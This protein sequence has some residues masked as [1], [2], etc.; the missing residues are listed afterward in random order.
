[1]DNRKKLA[2]SIIN[3]LKTEASSDKL[4]ED[5][6]EGL[7]VAIQCLETAYGLEDVNTSMSIDLFQIFND[8]LSKS[9]EG[10]KVKAENFKADG[11]NL[12]KSEKFHEAIECYTKAINNDPNNAVYY[13]NRAAAYTKLNEN[14]SAIHDCEKA[15]SIDPNYSKAYGRMG[16]VYLNE[17]NYQKAV[18]I[19]EKA[20]SMEPSNASY[21]TNLE[22]AKDNLKTN[23]AAAGA[24]AT[25]TPPNPLAGLDLNSLLSNPAVMNMAQSFMQNPQMQNMFANM[26]GGAAPPQPPQQPPPTQSA[27]AQEP[28]PPGAAAGGGGGGFQ[29]PAGLD[30]ANIMNAT[31]S[32]AEQMRQENPDLVD[33][34]RAQY[35]QGP[36]PG[37]PPS[38]EKDKNPNGTS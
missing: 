33:N 19:Y 15:I 35:Q 22:L 27:E 21:K 32:F 4:G 12:M 23:N 36:H 8:A 6:S 16:L 13:C 17:K 10:D 26:M 1:M 24:G 28:T 9:M 34:L 29:M 30:F 25:A 18:L 31:Q 20:V 37:A 7:E 14:E 38:E 2:A 3:F 11:N 5:A